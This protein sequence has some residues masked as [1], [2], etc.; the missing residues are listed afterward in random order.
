MPWPLTSLPGRDRHRGRFREAYRAALSQVAPIYR[1]LGRAAAERG[2]L[3][4]ADD[5]FFLP[6]E[7][8][9]HL[10][11]PHLPPWLAE[12]ARDNRAEHESLR[13]ADEPLDLMDERLEMARVEAER[14]EWTWSPLLPLP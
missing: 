4:D 8:A 2:L 9:E 14:P 10:A 1:A 6:L 13:K 7:L 5:A 12:A 11:S 3:G